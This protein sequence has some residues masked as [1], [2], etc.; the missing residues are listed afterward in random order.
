M[1]TI[2][3]N[4]QESQE[5][6]LF[7]AGDY[8]A[9]KNRQDGMTDNIKDEQKKHHLETVSKKLLEGLNTFGIANLTLIS[10]VDKDK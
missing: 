7:S 5:I 1:N 6:S 9:A 3:H 10:D 2:K 4:I 8:K